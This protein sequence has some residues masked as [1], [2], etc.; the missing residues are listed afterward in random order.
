[1]TAWLAEFC[2]QMLQGGNARTDGDKF[3][4]LELIAKCSLL[5]AR[6]HARILSRMSTTEVAFGRLVQ[7]SGR[8]RT[9]PKPGSSAESLG[10]LCILI[11]IS[12]A[13]TNLT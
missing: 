8:L 13:C 4:E 9:L 2:V 11:A 3:E 7:P 5:G 6:M 1:M 10:T 12:H